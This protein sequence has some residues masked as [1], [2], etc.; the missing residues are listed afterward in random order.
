M[1]L[2][3]YQTQQRVSVGERPTPVPALA[4]QTTEVVYFLDIFDEH[5]EDP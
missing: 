3:Q 2:L 5:A 1:E 4:L